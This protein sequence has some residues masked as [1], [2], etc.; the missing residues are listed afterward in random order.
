MRPAPIGLVAVLRPAQS[1]GILDADPNPTR[2]LDRPTPMRDFEPEPLGTLHHGDCI[3]GLKAMPAGSV[4][5]A[6]ADPPFNI[7]Y[8]YDVYDDTRGRRAL[9]RLVAAVGRS[10]SSAC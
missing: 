9:P 8:D 4:D 7:G 10:R 3:E 5:L 2:T 1:W 6:F